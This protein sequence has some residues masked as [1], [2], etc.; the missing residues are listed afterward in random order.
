MRV[1]HT[2]TSSQSLCVTTI[3]G[4]CGSSRIRLTC[5]IRLID[6]IDL[7]RQLAD[8]IDL[9]ARVRGRWRTRAREREQRKGV[10][11]GAARRHGPC[12][13]VGGPMRS[14]AR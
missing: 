2:Y 10:A 9:R 12:A 5:A 11:C 14:L 7:L 1:F 8:T 13:R 4:C 6:T 3:S